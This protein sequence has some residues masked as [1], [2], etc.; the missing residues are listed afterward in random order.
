MISSFE[1]IKWSSL[2]LSLTGLGSNGKGRWAILEPWK[3]AW[4]DLVRVDILSSVRSIFH[5]LFSTIWSILHNTL[6]QSHQ[7]FRTID[8][9]VV[10]ISPMLHSGEVH[11]QKYCSSTLPKAPSLSLTNDPP[12]VVVMTVILI[13]SHPGSHWAWRSNYTTITGDENDDNPHDCTGTK[14][15]LWYET[16]KSSTWWITSS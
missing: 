10:K 3:S 4:F 2:S 1:V 13:L 16:K 11:G 6:A 8:W 5:N 14:K 7:I 9:S 15:D 12:V